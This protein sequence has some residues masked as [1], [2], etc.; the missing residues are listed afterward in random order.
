MEAA[1]AGRVTQDP[2]EQKTKLD[3][4]VAKMTEAQK[5][6]PAVTMPKLE[7]IQAVSLKKSEE[8]DSQIQKALTPPGGA[9]GGPGFGPAA[10]VLA[11]PI[12]GDHV[13]RVNDVRAATGSSVHAICRPPSKSV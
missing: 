10:P 8:V 13:R 7:E 1:Q 4:L 11:R 5:N 2:E 6:N 3:D 9:P 12:P